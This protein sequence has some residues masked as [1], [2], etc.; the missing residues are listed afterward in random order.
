MIKTHEIIAENV[1]KLMKHK[2]MKQVEFAK[3]T[4]LSQRTISNA[5][6][7]G[8]V[9]SVTMDTVEK[10]AFYFGIEAYHLLI[11]NLSIA[12]L[13]DVRIEDVIN[14]YTET[15][16][17][18]RQQIIRT[19]DNEFRYHEVRQLASPAEPQPKEP[20]QEQQAKDL[21]IMTRKKPSQF[22]IELAIEQ[23][24]CVMERHEEAVIANER[25]VRLIKES[26]KQNECYCEPPCESATP[27]ITSYSKL[28]ERTKF[29]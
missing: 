27:R 14:K 5:L 17:H 26:C 24:R 15:S 12:D 9:G 20:N 4:G 8:S 29:I 2:Q 3:Q 1:D 18:G 19:A 7:P 23:E 6:K 13:I 25:Y 11:P 22:E 10:I 21:R 16:E 28:I